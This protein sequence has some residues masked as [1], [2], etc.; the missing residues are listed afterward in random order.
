MLPTTRL[1]IYSFY[2]NKYD[3]FDSQDCTLQPTRFLYT[4]QLTKPAA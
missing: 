1:K 2:N 4:D 3:L